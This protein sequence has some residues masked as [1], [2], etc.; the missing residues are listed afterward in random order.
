LQ[1]NQSVDV[2]S[3]Q[4]P[5]KKILF[6]EISDSSIKKLKSN[7]P[8]FFFL[9]FNLGNILTNSMPHPMKM[10][11]EKFL[12]AFERKDQTFFRG[13]STLSIRLLVKLMN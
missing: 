13:T 12:I 10:L 5:L 4:S 9:E 1:T 7:N 11:M 2:S 3:Y 6:K 8:K